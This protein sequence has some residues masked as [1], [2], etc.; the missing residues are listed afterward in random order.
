MHT[1]HRRCRMVPVKSWKCGS[2]GT[3]LEPSCFPLSLMQDTG[4]RVLST[5]EM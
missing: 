3:P 5:K 2:A 4:V 1:T